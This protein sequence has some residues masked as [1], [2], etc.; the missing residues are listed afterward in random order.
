MDKR[1][2]IVIN[3][4]LVFANLIFFSGIW[5]FI[6]SQ[7][8]QIE[9]ESALAI[10]EV[11]VPHLLAM[12]IVVFILCHFLLFIEDFNKNRALKFSLFLYLLVL[13]ENI[14][15]FKI[16]ILFMMGA[17]FIWLSY[18]LLSIEYLTNNRK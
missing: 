7:E 9:K 11:I 4:S 8:K 16:Y 10:L 3:Y 12:S 6:L 18:K 14:F 15:D 2:K 5:L 13:L 1:F 17:S